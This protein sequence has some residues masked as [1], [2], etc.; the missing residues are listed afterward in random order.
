MPEEYLLLATVYRWVGDDGVAAR[1]AVKIIL[2]DSPA[3]A[4]AQGLPWLA[5]ELP[6]AEGWE[7]HA[8]RVERLG[9]MRPIHVGDL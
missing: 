1:S 3:D 9:R 4:Q 2:A 8:L 6:P 5:E 7:G